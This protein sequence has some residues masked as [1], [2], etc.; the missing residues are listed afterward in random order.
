MNKEAC[1]V[2][3][4]VG[5]SMGIIGSDGKS[6][7]DKAKSAVR[8]M[9]TN[10]LIIGKKQ[11]EMGILLVGSVETFNQLNNEAGEGY[12]NIRTLSLLQKPSLKLLE[13]LDAIEVEEAE[14]DVIDSLLVAMGTLLDR[15]KKLKFTKRIYLAT[16][17]G[18]AINLDDSDSIDKIIDTINSNGFKL[19]VLGVGFGDAPERDENGS[20]RYPE[21]VSRNVQF[22]H[23]FTQRIGSDGGEAAAACIDVN[24][25]MQVLCSFRKAS[26]SISLSLF[27]LVIDNFYYL[28]MPS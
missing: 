13:E 2:I 19:N 9:I 3:I 11:D 25:A 14:G 6:G 26:V 21:P 20:F 10:K 24:D 16:A 23:E 12:D 7:L 28:A 8:Q 18:G 1:I 27:V 4:D 15:V 22:L 5:R 17:L